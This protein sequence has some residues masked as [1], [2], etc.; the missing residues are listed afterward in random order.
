S[1][2]LSLKQHNQ[3]QEAFLYKHLGILHFRRKAYGKALFYWNSSIRLYQKLDQPV[4]I[5]SLYTLIANIYE[6]EKDLQQTLDYH[7][8]ALSY[9]LGNHQDEQV[10]SSLLNIGNTYLLMGQQDSAQLYL[11]KGISMAEELKKNYL[12]KKGYGALYVFYKRKNN[13]VPALANF[14]KFIVY[15]DRVN[16]EDNKLLIATLETNRI[17]SQNEKETSALKAQNFIQKLEVQNK[18]LLV[19]ALLSLS[20]LVISFLIVAGRALVRKIKEKK[21]VEKKNAQLQVEIREQV[22]QNEELSRREQEYRFLA[23]HSADLISLM[24][25]TFK[26][27]YVSPSSQLFLGYSPEELVELQDYRELIH[28]ESRNSFAKA[29]ESMIEFGDSLRIIYQVIR[30]DG[31]AFW[32][33]SNINP[34]FETSSGKLKAMLSITR[35]VSSHVVKEEAWME[36]DR[37][38][39]MLIREVHHRVKNNLAILTGLVNMQKSEFTDSKT[40]EVFSDLQFRVKAMALVH[41]QLYRSQNIKIL[42]IG[43]YLSNLVRIV[44]SAFTTKTV[45]I[46]QSVYDEPVEVEI[47]LPLGL[48]VNELLT[49]AF[50]YA[51]PGN[52]NGNIWVTYKKAA[53]K[54]N[55]TEM[56]CLTVR[57]DGIG[58][59]PGFDITQRT[60]MGS[61]IIRLLTGELH[62]KLK[63]ENKKGAS[64]SIILPLER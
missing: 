43:N 9:R 39:E 22:I 21:L 16:D 52:R 14:E 56:R 24:D 60:S 32:V 55:G 1:L 47:T 4:H 20:L 38:K 5:G 23:D 50:K 25:S 2:F 51:F 64:F 12:L 49:N 58:L 13:I 63:V 3:V 27:L 31:S 6:E 45:E 54:K 11:E 28:P 59:P 34:V 48:I 7:K 62:G 18:K 53:T 29:I 35:D 33:E 26:C 10:A 57:D 44:S 42:P 37:Q 61:T 15:K 36:Q 30:K 40:L 17:I 19:L 8:I 46:H 41:D